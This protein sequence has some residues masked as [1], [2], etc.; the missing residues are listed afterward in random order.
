MTTSVDVGTVT[1]GTV[2]FE[3][4]DNETRELEV[5]A[6][7]LSGLPQRLI[8]DDGWLD[9]ARSLSSHLP[10]RLRQ[11]LR[12]FAWSPGADAMLLIRNLPVSAAD[13][14]DTPKVPLSVQRNTTVPA[15]ALVLT[16]LQLGEVMS[17]REEKFG[18]IVQDVVPVPRMEKFQG[19]AG[20]AELT[21]HVENAFH[22]HRPDYVGLLCLR[23]DHDNVAGLK[24]ASIRNAL[25]LLSP[26][27]RTV[28]G[29][30]RFVT[31]APDSFGGRVG[32]AKPMPVLIGHPD[33]PDIVV[34]FYSTAPIDD[35]ARDA[36]ERL[37]SALAD[38]CRI[39][40]LR[41]G[42]LAIVDNRLALHGR[43]SFRPRY[44]GR[45]RWLQ[46]VFVQ[47]DLR[48]SRACRPDG[49]RVIATN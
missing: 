38:T 34:D 8:D 24:I 21:M 16:A 40:H 11:V 37:G 19:N 41:P 25:P 22:P 1:H 13:L 14:P 28:L 46:R 4:N 35:T 45:D 43:T 36:L 9:A 15:S 6:A 47:L 31:A 32:P 10:T 18:A 5:V 33:D 49:R 17:Y 27:V 7:H 20:S 44:D 39:L 12:D 3:L 29:E 48:R 26:A 23:S 2:P 42:D 30:P